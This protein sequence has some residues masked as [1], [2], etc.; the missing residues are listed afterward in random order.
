MNSVGQRDLCSVLTATLVTA[1]KT[2]K[3]VFKMECNSVTKGSHKC[4][5]LIAVIT[6]HEMNQAQ[7][8]RY[9]RIPLIGDVWKS[10]QNSPHRRRL[11]DLSQNWNWSVAYRGWVRGTEQITS[12][13][14]CCLL[15]S[16]LQV[17]ASP[18]SSSSLQIHLIHLPSFSMSTN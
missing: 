4:P 1:V 10:L 5:S 9:Y 18:L 15:A 16:N 3:H 17:F 14:M 7:K 13:G 11:K 6:V 2:C 8:D 12:W